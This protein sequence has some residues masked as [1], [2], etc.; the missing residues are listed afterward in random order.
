[1]QEN[2]RTKKRQIN[3]NQEVFCIH[4]HILSKLYDLFGGRF[5]LIGLVIAQDGS[6]EP[7]TPD[8]LEA[9]AENPYTSRPKI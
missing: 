7:G 2:V 5:K 1:M 3:S 4:Q 6:S 9:K 8:P